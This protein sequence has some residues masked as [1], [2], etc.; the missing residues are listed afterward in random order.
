MHPIVFEFLKAVA[1]CIAVFFGLMDA[2]AGPDDFHAGGAIP[3]YGRITDVPGAAP[4]PEGV[5]LKHAFDVIP[6]AGAGSLNRRIESAARF[7]NMHHA[8]GVPVKDIRVAVVLHGPSVVDATKA[9]F[10]AGRKDGA[11]NANIPLIEALLAAGARII[12]CGQS[13]TAQDVYAGDLLPGV[14]LALSAMTAHA[15]LQQE[16]Y[17]LN[18]F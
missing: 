5:V 1:V 14:E 16:G 4:L 3:G 7:I 11:D 10:Y 9:D 18:P 12:V 6:A 15:I 13:A 2:E 17:T 8:A